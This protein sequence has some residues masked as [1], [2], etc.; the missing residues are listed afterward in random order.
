MLWV[1]SRY[2]EYQKVEKVNNCY[3]NYWN[4]T[5]LKL[6]TKFIWEKKKH[7]IISEMSWCNVLQRAGSDYCVYDYFPGPFVDFCIK[8]FIQ[9]RISSY[10]DP[11]P[12]DMQL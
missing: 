1:N 12:Q 7:S 10:V 6:K 8:I 11:C 5:M 9:E 2:A 3:K 4:K